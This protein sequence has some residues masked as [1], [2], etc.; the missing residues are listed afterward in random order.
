MAITDGPG[1]TPADTYAMVWD[2]AKGFAILARTAAPSNPSHA[3]DLLGV[4]SRMRDRARAI[5]RDELADYLDAACQVLALRE[6]G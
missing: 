6:S 3:R 1:A 4:A 2:M 5:E